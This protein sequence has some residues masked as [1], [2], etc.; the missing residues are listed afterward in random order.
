MQDQNTSRRRKRAAEDIRRL[1]SPTVDL[2]AL[3]RTVS[4]YTHPAPDRASL[5]WSAINAVEL[6]SL[7][8]VRA[9]TDRICSEIAPDLTLYVA[10]EGSTVYLRRWWLQ[11]EIGEDGRGCNGLYI[12]R[13]EGSDPAGFHDHPWTSASLMVGT[14]LFEDSHQGTTRITPGTVYI[15]PA[16]F[17]HRLRLREAEQGP[18]LHAVSIIATGERERNW[19]FET[20]SGKMVDATADANLYRTT[21]SSGH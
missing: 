1:L 15:R 20:P 8:R 18:G 19:G 14:G 6:D 21:A 10:G 16:R 5:A 7:A 13:F 4:A 3:A 11:R 17:R 9:V 12:H 2:E